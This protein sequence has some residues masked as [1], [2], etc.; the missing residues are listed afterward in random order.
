[1]DGKLLSNEIKNKVKEDVAMFCKTR[2]SPLLACVIVEGNNASET[3]VASKVRACEFCGIKSKVVRLPEN[4]S[5][6][7]L[8]RQIGLLNKDSEVSAILLQLPL[9]AHLDQ[10]HAINTILPEKDVDCLTNQNLGALFA[11]NSSFAPCTASG[12]IKLLDKYGIEIEG[13][14]A[15]VVG[16]SLLVG[17]SVATLLEERNATV[18]ICHSKTKNLKEITC[19]ADI[20]IV[21]VGKANF[22]T[23]NHIK[24]GA[25]V[26]DVGINRVDGK[27]LGDVDFK[28]VKKRCSFITPVPGG[29][30]PL[31]VACLMENTLT[32]A[33]N[34]SVKTSE[35]VKL[36]QAKATL[37]K[38]MK[39]K[40]LQDKKDN[41]S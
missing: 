30:G 10:T 11:K 4:I 24:K 40:E 26:V 38:K 17:K 37:L 41:K 23:K 27:I 21:A 15:V 2:K 6:S 29:V 8:E 13:K 9:P 7:E 12:I 16:R 31:T 39:E 35:Q 3:Y 32:L 20:L 36:N 33:K 18:T 28:K 25:V 22:I 5:Q 14:H 34:R 1:M 19:T